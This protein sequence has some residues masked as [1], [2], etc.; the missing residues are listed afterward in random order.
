M[1]TVIV[2]VKNKKE[3]EVLTAFLSSLN[4]HYR[5]EQDEDKA[6]VALYKQTKNKKEKAVPF[7]ANKL[8]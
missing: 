2:N 1:E 8:Q 6:L 3:K 5:T 4:M 7:D